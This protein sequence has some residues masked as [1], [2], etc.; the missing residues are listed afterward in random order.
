MWVICYSIL[1]VI[2][3]ILLSFFLY[4]NKS[5]KYEIQFIEGENH[6]LNSTLT[7]KIQ[8]LN[9]E[10]K[11]LMKRN[12]ILE[13]DN[14][15]LNAKNQLNED[16][17]KDFKEEISRIKEHK[18]QISKAHE[19]YKIEANNLREKYQEY[20]KQN[21]E[22]LINRLEKSTAH[23][24]EVN[25]NKFIKDS[26]DRL[27]NLLQPLKSKIDDFQKQ[28][29][30]HYN[31]ELEGRTSLTTE[32][33]LIADASKNVAASCNNLSQVLRGEQKIQGNW[34]ELVLKKVLEAS[35]LR[36]GHEYH[37]QARMVSADDN[38]RADRADVVISLPENRHIVVDAKTSLKHY[39]AY[40]N[41]T[42]EEERNRCLTNFL[43]SV[44]NHIKGLSKKEYQRATNI[45]S[46]DFTIMFIPMDSAFIMAIQNDQSIQDFAL[47]QNIIISS[48]SLLLPILKTVSS[49]WQL[50]QQNANAQN[51]VLKASSMYEKFCGFI[52]DMGNIDASLERARKSYDKAVNKLYDG[53]GNLIKQSQDIKNMGLIT[54]PNKSIPEEYV[55]KALIEKEL[56]SV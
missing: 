26:K 1:S 44:K 49:L 45:K 42:K 35:G 55:E 17:I 6:K 10:S 12:S 56:E 54:K 29:R 41:S 39:D 9:E 25:S 5:L 19:Q 21:S 48:P 30:D 27:D 40:F 15:S 46:P 53:K 23:N 52:E 8:E 43:E 16:R 36:E 11:V 24:L 31:K 14:A 2:V 37:F 3:I 7:A 13:Q 33:K 22:A 20:I 51:I 38:T 50:S 47:K 28:A 4:K 34:G 18:D 32:I